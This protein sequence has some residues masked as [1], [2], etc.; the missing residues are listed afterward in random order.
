MAKQQA[1]NQAEKG[2]AAAGRARLAAQKAAQ[3]G[4]FDKQRAVKG[5][6]VRMGLDATHAFLPCGHKFICKECAASVEA[7]VTKWYMCMTP[8]VAVHQIFEG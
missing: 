7:G 1:G 2:A 6:I 8:C 4:D 5:C 3:G